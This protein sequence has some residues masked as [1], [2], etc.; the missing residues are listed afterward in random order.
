VIAIENVRQFRELQTQLE[1]QTATAEVLKVISQ[2]AFDLP[3]V[4]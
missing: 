2:S 3:T 1:Q 4:L